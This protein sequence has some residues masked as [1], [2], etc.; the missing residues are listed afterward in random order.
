MSV[1]ITVDWHNPQKTILRQVY[2][3]TWSW[4]EYVA[5]FRRIGALAA[6]VDHPIGIIAETGA[7]RHI[8]RHAIMYGSRAVKHL[9]P[10]VYLAVIV[11]PSAFVISMMTIIAKITRYR[12]RTAATV[13]E[14]QAILESA[15]SALSPP[16]P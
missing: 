9:P 5:S 13:E 14:A 1:S 10:N 2:D 6:E 16:T 3:A 11:S 7:V 12:W 8:P 15:R 4:D